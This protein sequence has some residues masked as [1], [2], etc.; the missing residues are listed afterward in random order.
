LKAGETDD[1][2]QQFSFAF[3]PGVVSGKKQRIYAADNLGMVYFDKKEYKLSENWFK[4]ALSYN[5][6]FYKPYYNLGLIYIMKAKNGNEPSYY[7]KAEEYLKIATKLKRRFGTANL[8]LAALYLE[9][10][11]M[12]KA[13]S[14]A[15]NAIRSGLP[16]PLANQARHIIAITGN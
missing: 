5:P 15:Q 9:L 6:R 11:E 7:R 10:G 1:A 2:I 13:R 12:E 14:E 16:E 8:A 3:V 4:K